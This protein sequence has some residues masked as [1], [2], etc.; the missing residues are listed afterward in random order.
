MIMHVCYKTTSKMGKELEFH[1]NIIL[2]DYNF[3]YKKNFAFLAKSSMRKQVVN[4]LK[5]TPWIF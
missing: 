5:V 4:E 1:L 2:D 3:F